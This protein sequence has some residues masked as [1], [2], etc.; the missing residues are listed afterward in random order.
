[1]VFDAVDW[2]NLLD[3]RRLADYDLPARLN[4]ATYITANTEESADDAYL[5]H[6]ALLPQLPLLDQAPTPDPYIIILSSARLFRQSRYGW[7]RHANP[8]RFQRIFK[9]QSQ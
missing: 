7:D 9:S 5:F 8:L 3:I 6:R 2:S 4:T 1:V